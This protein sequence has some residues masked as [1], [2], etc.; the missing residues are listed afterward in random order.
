MNELISKAVQKA[1]QVEIFRALAYGAL[2]ARAARIAP[3]QIIRI[4]EFDLLVAEDEN[5]DGLVVQMEGL[6]LARASPSICTT[7]P[8]PFSSS[9]TSRSNSPI[10]IIWLGAILAAR[11]FNAP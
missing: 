11:A 7:S 1:S 4:G 5:G 2:K 8:S 3:N 10:L 9:A 6:A